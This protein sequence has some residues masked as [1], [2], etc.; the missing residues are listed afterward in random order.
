ML[1]RF[2]HKFLC[3]SIVV[4]DFTVG[5]GT[6]GL[7]IY[8]KTPHGDLWGKFK[9]EKFLPHDDVGLLSMANNGKNRN[10]SQVRQML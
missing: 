5:D 10:G 3:L 9:D 7:S 4:V 8:G 1:I 6:G 2:A